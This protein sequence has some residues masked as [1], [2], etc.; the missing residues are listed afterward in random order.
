M[1]G[2]H[3]DTNAFRCGLRGKVMSDPVIVVTVSNEQLTCGQSYERSVLE[4]FL[5]QLGDSETRFVPNP[6]LKAL[7]H[8]VAPFFPAE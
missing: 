1:Q 5:G 6:Y 2:T 8:A 7:L 4:T 3:I